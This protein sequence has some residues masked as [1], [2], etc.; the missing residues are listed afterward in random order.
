MIRHRKFVRFSGRGCTGC[1]W[2]IARIA[3]IDQVTYREDDPPFRY[4]CPSCRSVWGPFVKVRPPKTIEM[5]RV[6]PWDFE[7]FEAPSSRKCRRCGK[8]ICLFGTFGTWGDS[9]PEGTVING[10]AYCWDC[11]EKTAGIIEVMHS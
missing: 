11:V 10:A 5:R 4:E 9:E 2:E 6:E 8:P 3:R 7:F 1:K